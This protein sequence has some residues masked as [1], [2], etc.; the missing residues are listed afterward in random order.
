[1]F[2]YRIIFNKLLS[3]EYA[4]QIKET[5]F[6]DDKLDF[7]KIIPQPK[8]IIKPGYYTKYHVEA[9][10][11]YIFKNPDK[12]SEDELIECLHSQAKSN[13]ILTKYNYLSDNEKSSVKKEVGYKKL[14]EWDIWSAITYGDRE[15]LYSTYFDNKFILSFET[16]LN[17][18]SGILIDRLFYKLRNILPKEI[19]NNITLEISYYNYICVEI[20]QHINGSLKLV[21][22]INLLD[23]I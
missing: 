11:W 6:T 18:V 10:N 9:Y 15:L 14:P 23:E 5:F 20:Y 22:E 17:K 4:K 8:K 16:K 7:N 1:M 12:L 21:D 2:V 13:E 3:E 19:V